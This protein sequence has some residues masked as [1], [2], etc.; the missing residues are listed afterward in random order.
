MKRRSIV[1]M[2]TV[3]AF[4]LATG[5]AN[6]QYSSQPKDDDKKVAKVGEKAPTFTLA[7]TDGKEHNLA[8]YTKDGKIVVLE[9]FNPDCPWVKAHHGGTTDMT[10]ETQKAFK[11]KDVVFLAINSGAKGK[12]G[13]GQER[14][15]K[16]KKDFEMAYP[17]LLDESGK[18]GK[19][20][21]AETT[22]HI[23]IIDA[24]GVLRYEGAPDKMKH[25][26]ELGETNMIELT[27]NAILADETVTT[28][29]TENYGCG[30]KY[31][32]R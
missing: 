10:A 27:L 19:S 28:T 25:G 7:D 29:N 5:V 6:A 11:D 18:V 9:W 4:C 14:N 26:E 1:S 3:G 16:A 12:Q 30:V 8:D 21:D 22:P 23:Y 31:A 20:Y 13:A 2:L 32:R 24:E 17:I 15:A